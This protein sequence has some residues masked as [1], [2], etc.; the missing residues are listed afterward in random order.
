MTAEKFSLRAQCPPADAQ[1]PRPWSVACEMAGASARLSLSVLKQ[2]DCTTAVPSCPQLTVAIARTRQSVLGDRR[3]NN[4][5]D[6]QYGF[7]RLGGALSR[8]DI[9]ARWTVYSSLGSKELSVKTL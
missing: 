9:L 8:Y 3:M 7:T 2:H 5:R 4:G 6:S 1:N